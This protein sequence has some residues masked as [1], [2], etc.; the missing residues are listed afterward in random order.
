M[1]ETSTVKSKGI[2]ITGA[3][4]GIGAAAAR[5]LAADGHYAVVVGRPQG[6]TEAVGQELGAEFYLAPFTKLIVVSA[7]TG[8]LLEKYRLI[9][10]LANNAGGVFSNGRYV[11]PPAGEKR[12]EPTTIKTEDGFP[13]SLSAREIEVLSLIAQGK[14]N[15]EISAQL[16][17]ALNTVKRHAYN[18]YAKL[19]VKKRTHAVWKARQLGLIP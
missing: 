3:S 10:V 15:Q 17:L 9:E 12:T 18:I 2:V 16:F 5:Q 7:P 14:S 13:I 19:E 6:Q 8:K 11:L 4:D 1:M